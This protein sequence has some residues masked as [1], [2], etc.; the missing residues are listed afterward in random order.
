MTM[1]D[2][3]AALANCSKLLNTG[4]IASIT[5]YVVDT[6]KKAGTYHGGQISMTKILI[7]IAFVMVQSVQYDRKSWPHWIDEDGDCQN[8]R[9]EILIRDNVGTIKFKRNKPCNVS[10]GKWICPYTGKTF[11]KA[12]DLDIDHIVPLSHAHRTGGANW[13][14]EK[15]REF[16]ND[17]I[18]LLAVEDNTNQSKGD[19]G[20]AEWMPPR[21]EYWSEYARKWRAVKKKYELSIS[22]EEEKLL[23]ACS[24]T[25]SDWDDGGES[26]ERNNAI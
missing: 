7:L 3:F 12:S 22:D 15:K 26:Y 4:K 1:G 23:R 5:S 24:G 8:T 17:P 6:L 20:P 10:W 25:F 16:A 2:T 21:K 13:T 11:T 9:A 14:R 18:N 19:K